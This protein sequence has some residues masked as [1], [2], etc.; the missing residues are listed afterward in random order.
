MTD[1]VLLSTQAYSSADIRF[2][3]QLIQA[4]AC[5]P[6]GIQLGY[7]FTQT[8]CIDVGLCIEA[9][10]FLKTDFDYLL[11]MDYDILFNPHN[12]P[13]WRPGTEIKRIVDSVK[14]TGGLVA[15]PYM[16]RGTGQICCVPLKAES[17]VIG[18]SGGLM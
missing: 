7:S 4:L 1:K 9:T 12:D 6:E 3:N 2:I 16:K 15:G 14:E 8:S 18:P 10:N 5:Q 17:G 11:S 13:T